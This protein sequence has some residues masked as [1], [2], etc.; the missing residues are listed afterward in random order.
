MSWHDQADTRLRSETSRLNRRSRSS[1]PKL[2]PN[3]QL[4]TKA[5]EPNRIGKLTKAK[6]CFIF[7]Q[8]LL[9]DSSR[10]M[11]DALLGSWC[12]SKSRYG[13]SSFLSINESTHCF[14]SSRSQ[15]NASPPTSCILLM[16]SEVLRL[17]GSFWESTTC[18]EGIS[19]MIGRLIPTIGR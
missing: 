14:S 12:K 4:K 15:S 7:T 13:S 5:Q 1:R 16:K 3:E 6:T 19:V 17:L 18:S 10:S 2:I 11:S 8:S 9:R